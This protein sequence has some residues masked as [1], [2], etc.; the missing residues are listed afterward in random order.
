MFEL[1]ALLG[2][3][4]IG[5][6][7][8]GAE[9]AIVTARRGRLESA[10]DGGSARARAAL[11]LRRNPERF[12][13]T[14]Q[15][16]IT[17]VGAVA[18]AYGGESLAKPLEPWLRDLGCGDAAPKIAFGAVMALVTYL[19]VVFGE[20]VPKSL[21]L[22]FADRYAL[23]IAR[24]MV[25]LGWVG[26]PVAWLL[27]VSS[28]LVLRLFGDRTNF[29]EGKLGREDLQHLVEEASEA[30]GI[31]ERTGQLVARALEFTQLR[32]ADVMVPRR[33]VQAVP[34]TADEASLRTAMLD[35]GHRRVPVYAESI[36][37]VVGYVLREDVLAKLWDKQPLRLAE[38]V[39]EPFFVPEAM[40]A[41]RA[42][43][44]LQHRRV[45]LAVVVEEHGGTA[46]LVTLEDLVEE[47]VG[48][49]F[50]ERDASPP[51]PIVREAAGVWRVLGSVAPRDLWHELRVEI[52][53]PGEE[54]TLSGL[55]VALAGDRVP[56]VG[57]H[58]RPAPHI[59]IEVIE[60]SPRRVRAV[61]LRLVADP[62]PKADES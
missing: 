34:Q 27:A 2:L 35:Q 7:L 37:H 36:D 59:D 9:M 50:H 44:E 55:I 24:P 12:L 48:E 25:L 56:G 26:R 13:A 54:R 43:R 31:D 47:L 32:V 45:H 3:V 39:R 42:L 20:L 22:R 53:A 38:L 1:L 62:L 33:F 21:A 46:G 15:I 58:F 5:G 8:A 51:R 49:I 23:L 19:S 11:H 60:A 16:G 18:G 57:E 28:N 40:A 4:A 61:R 30:G 29:V 52:P 14:V 17:L 41:E 6:V 10:A